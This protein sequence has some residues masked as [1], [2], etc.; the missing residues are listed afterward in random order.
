M[1]LQ[2]AADGFE[3]GMPGHQL[4]ELVSAPFLAFEST[5]IQGPVGGVHPFTNDSA[6]VNENTSYRSLVCRKSL[7][8]LGHL[9]V[10][11]RDKHP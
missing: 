5:A 4:T 3:L 1:L 9:S 11:L 8:C 7:L 10:M 2:D 6:I